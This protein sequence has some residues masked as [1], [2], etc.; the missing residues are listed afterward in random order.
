[1][2]R[3]WKFC[4]ALVISGAMMAGTMELIIRG[5]AYIF[6]FPLPVTLASGTGTILAC[7]GTWVSIDVGKATWTWTRSRFK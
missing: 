4:L 5:G 7:V 3:F 6:K 1:M 2:R